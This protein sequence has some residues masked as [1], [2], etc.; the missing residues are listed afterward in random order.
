MTCFWQ[1]LLSALRQF[2][3]QKNVYTFITHLQ[4]NNKKTNNVFWNNKEFTQKQ[5]IENYDWVKSFDITIM[6]HGERTF[7]PWG[8]SVRSVHRV[9]IFRLDNKCLGY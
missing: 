6:N 9:G 7:E 5:L 3:P 1:G 2:Y 8:M 4:N